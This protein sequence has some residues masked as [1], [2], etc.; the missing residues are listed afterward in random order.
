MIYGLRY[1]NAIGAIDFSIASGFVVEEATSYGAQDVGFDTT[2]SN[3]EIGEALQHQSVN[4]KTLTIRGTILGASRDARQQMNHIIAPL[5]PGRLTYEQNGESYY[6]DCYVK[7]S[8]DVEQ[9][10][11]NARFTFSLYAPFPYWRKTNRESTVLVGYQPRFIFP[12]NISDPNPFYFSETAQ[13]GYVTVTNEGEAPA[14]WTVTFTALST[15]KN[16]YA[17]DIDTGETVRVLKT[18]SA[19]ESVTISTEGEELSVTLTAADG[20]ETDGFQYLD[21]ESIPF[22]LALGDNHIKTDADEGGEGLRSSISFRPAYAG[23]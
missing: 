19:G 12:W 14:D 8:P 17:Q 7:T 13:V 11:E 3:R 23:V 22:R 10:N 9:Y 6:L 4:P 15:V 1:S 20:T 2:R 18:L 16:P 21:I 5:A